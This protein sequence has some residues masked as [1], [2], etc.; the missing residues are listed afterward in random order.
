MLALRKIIP[1]ICLLII[2]LEAQFF[3]DQ[4]SQVGT[5]I[6]TSGSN[7][8]NNEQGGNIF[9]KQSQI[10]TK[11]GGRK[12]REAQFL[13]IGTQIGLEES[14]FGNLNDLKSQIRSSL[15]SKGAVLSNQF[16]Q[17]NQ[18]NQA[19]FGSNFPTAVG[20]G[21]QFG[22]RKKREALFLN[23][24]SGVGT[25]ELG[26]NFQNPPSKIGSQQGLGSLGLG[27]ITQL[28]SFSAG[29]RKKRDAQF[30]N[31]GIPQIRFDGSKF[32]NKDS[33]IG[34]ELKRRVELLSGLNFPDPF[35]PGL[36]ANEYL[37]LISEN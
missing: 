18:F 30:N 25:Q 23:I 29:G 27:S 20:S 35:L 4:N 24:R 15:A 6:S 2:E 10:G 13:N 36:T 37:R 19:G 32:D 28:P 3:N 5:Q 8:F 7:F 11:F 12:K 1:L 17:T 21:T 34:Q 9:N 16:S 22:G 14:S 33:Q 26:S 31:E